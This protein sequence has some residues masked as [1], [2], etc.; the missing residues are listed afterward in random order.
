MSSVNKGIYFVTSL[1]P[2]K[3]M[4]NPSQHFLSSIE[5]TYSSIIKFISNFRTEALFLI[6]KLL[7]QKYK[8]IQDEFNRL[9]SIIN[10]KKEG[11]LYANL[12]D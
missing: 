8:Y 7:K 5:T 11:H 6:R 4:N 10:P 1:V 12:L 9:T 3:N 2:S